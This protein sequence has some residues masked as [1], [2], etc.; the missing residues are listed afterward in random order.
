MVQLDALRVKEALE[1]FG[2]STTNLGNPSK[3]PTFCSSG[4]KLLAGFMNISCHEDSSFASLW[5]VWTLYTW[6]KLYKCSVGVQPTLR[7]PSPYLNVQYS[8]AVEVK[9][10]QVS[11]IFHTTKREL[12]HLILSWSDWTRHPT[13]DNYFNN[14]HTDV[15]MCECVYIYSMRL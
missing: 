13:K 7:F 11:W 8:V 1:M 15:Y 3:Q 5:Y 10:W 6:K 12:I 9:Y 2:W 14:P 4:S